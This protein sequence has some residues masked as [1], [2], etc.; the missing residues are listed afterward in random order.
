MAK[1]RKPKSQAVI[2]EAREDLEVAIRDAADSFFD[3]VSLRVSEDAS[4]SM[5]LEVFDDVV[6]GWKM[7]LEE[8]KG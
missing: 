1:G 3:A 4:L 2:D 7:R 5:V 8:L 6:S